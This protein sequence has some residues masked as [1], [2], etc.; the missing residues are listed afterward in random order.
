MCLLLRYHGYG[1]LELQSCVP[2]NYS[3]VVKCRIGCL[4]HATGQLDSSTL[5]SSFCLNLTAKTVQLLKLRNMDA[6]WTTWEINESEKLILKYDVFFFFY[7]KAPRKEHLIENH[8][9]STS[10]FD[11]GKQYRL[12]P[13]KPMMMPIDYKRFTSIYQYYLQ[14]LASHGESE[15]A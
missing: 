8:L 10:S 9:F 1:L 3:W 11:L 13:I 15:A 6:F 5:L 7:K 4:P 14:S 12:I 2:Q